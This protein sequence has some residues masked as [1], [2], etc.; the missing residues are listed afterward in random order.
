MELGKITAWLQSE[1]PWAP[2]VALYAAVGPSA[3]Y[4]RL[5]ALPATPYSQ[6]VLVREL[7]ALVGEVRQEIEALAPPPEPPAP[8]AVVSP[9][10]DPLSR[11]E[12]SAALDQVRGQLRAVR[13][14]RSHLHPQLTAKNLGKAARLALSCTI[15][16]LTDQEVQLKDLEAHVLAHGR[17]PGPVP[18]AEITDAGVLR[19]RLGNLVSQRTKLRKNPARADD[20]AAAEAEITL[21]RAKL[22]PIPS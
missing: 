2:G 14:Q 7:T 1:Q 15:C 5:F 21:I 3:T 18:T 10:P 11:G 19:Q 9:S 4:K 16:D 17:L 6:G 8:A 13:D 22:M 12:G 20:L